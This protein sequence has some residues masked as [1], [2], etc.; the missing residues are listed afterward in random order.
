MG[1]ST[2]TAFYSQVNKT[3]VTAANGFHHELNIVLF[4]VS[5]SDRNVRAADRQRC[6]E[7]VL[8]EMVRIPRPLFILCKDNINGPKNRILCRNLGQDQA[9]QFGKPK[10]K[11]RKIIA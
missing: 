7:D 11:K 6:M 5:S 1:S 9:C 2:P 4:N 3:A 10:K 8:G